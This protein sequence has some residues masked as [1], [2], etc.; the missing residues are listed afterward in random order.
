MTL[1]I[2]EKVLLSTRGRPFQRVMLSM[3]IGSVIWL[4]SFLIQ[5]GWTE[6]WE[7]FLSFLNTPVGAGSVVAWTILPFVAAIGTG[8][9]VFKGYLPARALFLHAPMPGSILRK[10]VHYYRVGDMSLLFIR[11][12][13]SF[14]A[15]ALKGDDR[16]AKLAAKQ[17]FGEYGWLQRVIIRNLRNNP[18]V[19]AQAATF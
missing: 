17:F 6:P 12:M 14:L 1:T 19:M 11:Q 18:N 7:W 16:H 8:L 9:E 2:P 13:N 4:L 5:R 3:W 15:D 10:G